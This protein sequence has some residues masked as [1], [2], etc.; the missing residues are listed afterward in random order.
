MKNAAKCDMWCELQ[1]SVNH[2]MFERNLRPRL[3]PRACLLERRV[4]FPPFEIMIG[5]M[6]PSV[7]LVSQLAEIHGGMCWLVF[8]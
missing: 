5:R 6:W 8:G 2:R 7:E 4:T 3:E 1:N